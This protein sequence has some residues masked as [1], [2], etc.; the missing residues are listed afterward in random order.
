LYGESFPRLA[1]CMIIAGFNSDSLSSNG[2]FKLARSIPIHSGRLTV[3]RDHMVSSLD[4]TPLMWSL[5]MTIKA[6]IFKS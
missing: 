1:F 3:N 6:T 2:S 5:S 4:T